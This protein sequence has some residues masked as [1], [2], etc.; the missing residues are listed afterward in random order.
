MERLVRFKLLGHNF[1][2]YTDALDE[3]VEQIISLVKEEVESNS[4]QNRSTVPS[5]KTLILACLQLAARY[6]EL[7][8]EFSTYR[9]QQ[10]KRIDTLID[11]V[12]SEIK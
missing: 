4:P 1:S 12:A 8:R 3:D 7:K 2:F 11:K 10:D 5:S 6:V 9:Q